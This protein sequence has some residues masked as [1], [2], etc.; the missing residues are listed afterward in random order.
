MIVRSGGFEHVA[1]FRVALI[2]GVNLHHR[3]AA[4]MLNRQNRGARGRDGSRAS[5]AQISPG[6]IFD[7]VAV[8]GLVEFKLLLS[9]EIS[10]GVVERD[11]ALPVVRSL[12]WIKL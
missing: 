8:D 6:G 2:Q 3:D 12:R 11:P 1:D 4:V 5:H 10:S 9:V 7:I